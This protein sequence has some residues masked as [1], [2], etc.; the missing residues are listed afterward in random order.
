MIKNDL[1]SRTITLNQEEQFTA[2]KAAIFLAE[3][4]SNYWPTATTGSVLSL[5]DF[6]A[7][8]AQ[9][10]ASEWVVAK[11]MGYGFDPYKQKGKRI[12]DVGDNL[13]IRWTKYDY[14]KLIVRKYDR[15][16]DIAI[17]VTGEGPAYTVVG[18]MPVK[19]AR[20]DKYKHPTQPNYW[21][22]QPDLRTI[23]MALYANT[24]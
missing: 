18:A 14:G 22:P 19:M 5:H 24:L 4:N 1:I 6:L 13:E 12:A 15:N 17:L 3:N 11:L 20:T 7:Q 9:S 2:H 10:I 21:V 8:D 16:E 23:E